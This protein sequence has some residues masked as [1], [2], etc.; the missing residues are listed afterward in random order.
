MAIQWLYGVTIMSFKVL[1]VYPNTPLLNPPPVSIGVITALLKENGIDVRVFDTTFYIEKENIS[2]DK[3]KEENLQVRPFSFDKNQIPRMDATPAEDLHNL[4]EKYQPGLIGVSV[5]EGTWNEGTELLD[6]ISGFDIPVIVGG[7]FA[8]FSP[9]IILEHPCVDMVCIGE[10]EYSMLELCQK[11]ENNRVYN[12]IENIWVKKKDGT[13]IKNPVRKV[14]D[15]NRLPF[16]DYSVFHSARFLRP[17]AGKVYRAVPVETNRGCPFGC[18]FCNSPAISQFYRESGAGNFFRKKS[19]DRIRDELSFFINTWDAEYVYFLS[20]TFLSMTDSEFDVFIEIYEKYKLP[21]WIQTRVETLTQYRADRLKEVGCH[22]MSIGIE[23]GNS[24][25]RKK[26]LKKKFSNQQV[27]NATNYLAKAG[28]PLSVNNIIGFPDE[29]RELVFDT[30]ELNRHIIFDTS[31]AYVFAPFH[32]TP[33]HKYSLEK[34]YISGKDSTGCITLDTPLDMPQF[35]QGEISG[36]RKTFALY[37]KMPK[38]YWPEIKKAEKN[39]EEGK[40]K[41]IELRKIY[42]EKYF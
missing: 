33:L 36:L 31:N 28:I 16:P 25:F 17:M 9:E 41:F 23:H 39:N 30:I 27:I 29:T 14:V 21:F 18:S 7:V 3:A 34:G 2:S 38:K 13:I 35:S 10:G 22:R 6:A 12:N 19:M 32:G 26:V 8:T 11:L 37:A 4:I 42:Q 15:I 5:L 1:L 20:D 24:E 40:A